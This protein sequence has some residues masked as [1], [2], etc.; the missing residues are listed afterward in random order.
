MLSTS[1]HIH[2]VVFRALLQNGRYLFHVNSFLIET[3]CS[4]PK[5]LTRLNK[6]GL[7]VSPPKTDV[8]IKQLGE[9]HDD[10]VLQWRKEA[11]QADQGLQCSAS[12]VHNPPLNLPNDGLPMTSS[13][14][15][16]PSSESSDIPFMD[17][18]STESG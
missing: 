7:C 2:P 11:E 12:I 13:S 16:V 6:L 9:N 8:L 10:V 14:D 17:I 15:D 3:C 4:Y 1:H 5:V 18:L